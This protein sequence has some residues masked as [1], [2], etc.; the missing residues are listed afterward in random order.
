MSL[1]GPDAGH[2]AGPADLDYCHRRGDAE[3]TGPA[4]WGS[5]RVSCLGAY[6]PGHTCRVAV[7]TFRGNH[8]AVRLVFVFRGGNQFAAK[9]EL[10]CRRAGLAGDTLCDQRALAALP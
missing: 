10:V 9:A 3:S 2:I 8:I 7:G 6:A 1:D 4:C 5:G